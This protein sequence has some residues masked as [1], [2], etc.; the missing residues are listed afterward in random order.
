MP[1][2]NAVSINPVVVS[3]Y[4]SCLQQQESWVRDPALHMTEWVFTYEEATAAQDVPTLIALLHPMHYVKGDGSNIAS[5]LT[6]PHIRAEPKIRIPH[7]RGCQISDLVSGIHC[8]RLA[9]QV[10]HKF[11]FALGGA[12]LAE[13]YVFLCAICNQMKS[14]SVLHFDWQSLP[15]WAELRLNQLHLCKT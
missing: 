6:P 13:N 14:T 8:G 15:E 12:N 5:A 9:T 2:A 4:L 11:P 10:D 3:R 7:A 1:T